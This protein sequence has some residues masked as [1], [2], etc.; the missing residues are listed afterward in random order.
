MI[1]DSQSRTLAAGGEIS[2]AL[3]RTGRL[4]FSA[5]PFMI[6]DRLPS[7]VAAGLKVHL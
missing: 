7:H 2:Q 1:A 4:D 3:K 6:A 5:E